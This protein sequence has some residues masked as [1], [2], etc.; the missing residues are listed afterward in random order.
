MPHNDQFYRYEPLQWYPHMGP[1]DAELWNK[2][3]ITNPSKFTGVVYDM[4]CG[5]TEDPIPELP[6][7]IKDAWNDLCRW[8]IDVVASTADAVYTIE[9]RP[10]ALADALGN[11]RGYAVLYEREHRPEKKVIPL[12]IT[13]FIL[14]NTRIIAHA[15]KIEIWTPEQTTPTL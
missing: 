13:D 1:K 8:R 14:P 2:F 3:V 9:V 4:R 15:R 6:K 7:R 12:V 11:A 5:E 10:R